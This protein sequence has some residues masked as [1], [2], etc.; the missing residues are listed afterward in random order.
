MKIL[1]TRITIQLF[2]LVVITLFIVILIL[3]YYYLYEATTPKINSLI[4]SLLAGSIVAFFQLFLSWYEHNTIEKFKSMQIKKVLS[5]RDDR[6]FYQNL[7]SNSKKK[8]YV[9]GVTADRFIEHFAD[10][11]GDQERSKVLLHAMQNRKVKVRI[12][13]PKQQYLENPSSK[14]K[15]DM[16]YNCMVEIKQKHPN[17]KF[18]YFDHIAQHSIFIIDEECI[19]GPVLPRVSSKDTPAI[20][21]KNTSPYAQKYLE[22]FDNEWKASKNAN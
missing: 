11:K 9:M 20:Y 19:L 2:R 6:E 10:I 13:L 15:F 17:F 21:L 12:L 4:G 7:I 1:N 18:R 5:N 16:V 8:I 22:Y 3:F 14:D